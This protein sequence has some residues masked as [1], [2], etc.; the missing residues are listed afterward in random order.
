MKLIKNEQI[1]HDLELLYGMDH[2]VLKRDKNE[3]VVLK[4]EM[5]DLIHKITCYER[6]RDKNEE[7]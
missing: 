5:D 2:F 3:V 4:E 1:E 6:N 7:I